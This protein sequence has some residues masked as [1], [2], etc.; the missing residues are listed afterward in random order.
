LKK[1]EEKK[2]LYSVMGIRIRENNPYGSRILD[3]Y[4]IAKS[5][6]KNLVIQ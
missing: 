2:L 4:R 3:P 6:D 1:I 5:K